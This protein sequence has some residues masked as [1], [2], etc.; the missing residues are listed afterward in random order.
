MYILTQHNRNLFIVFAFIDLAKDVMLYIC[1]FISKSRVQTIQLL[2]LVTYYIFQYHSIVLEIVITFVILISQI[3]LFFFGIFQ[4]YGI[5]ACQH[6]INQINIWKGLHE[7][8]IVINI[9]PHIKNLGAAICGWW[10]KTL[11]GGAVSESTCQTIYCQ[12]HY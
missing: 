1:G 6:E 5:Y 4:H 11:V 8:V 10:E 7:N 2:S 12:Q 3:M 9:L